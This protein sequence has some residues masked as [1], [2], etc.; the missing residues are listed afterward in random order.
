MARRPVRPG[1]PGRGRRPGAVPRHER[2]G[3]APPT[4]PGDEVELPSAWDRLDEITVPTLVLLGDLDL[5][6]I[7]QTNEGLAERIPDAT[8]EVLDR[9]R[10]RPPPGGPRPL[11][12]GDP[13]VPG[14][15]GAS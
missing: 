14:L 9:H 15:S 5:E 13:R 3:P 1:G 6:D 12:G 2:P 8:F 7:A 4:R 10:P 11:P